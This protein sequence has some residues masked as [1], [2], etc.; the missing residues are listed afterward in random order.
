V[1]VFSSELIFGINMGL[2][3]LSNIR[4]CGLMTVIFFPVLWKIMISEKRSRE[5]TTVRKRNIQL[6]P[7]GILD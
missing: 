4:N 1:H 5:E 7:F 3:Y 6:R 2:E